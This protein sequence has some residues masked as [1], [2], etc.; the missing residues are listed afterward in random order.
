MMLLLLLLVLG[1][2]LLLLLVLLLCVSGKVLHEARG[3]SC[4]LDRRV[5][6]ELLWGQQGLGGDV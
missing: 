5:Y 2:V 6:T 4:H 3:V 1:V